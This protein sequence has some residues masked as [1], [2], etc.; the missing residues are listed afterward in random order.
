MYC[1][2]SNYLIQNKLYVNSKIITSPQTPS[3]CK[4]CTRSLK[5]AKICSFRAIYS[6]RFFRFWFFR[7]SY[8]QHCLYLRDI[9]HKNVES[10]GTVKKVLRTGYGSYSWIPWWTLI[11]KMTKL[12]PASK[13]GR[14][15][16]WVKVEHFHNLAL[17]GRYK[18][19]FFA[20]NDFRKF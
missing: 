16:E 15:Y 11:T 10:L 20:I 13:S 5:F 7:K 17:F 19:N 12:D 6:F 14:G 2:K 18:E 3:P 8:L 4:K 9:P 1:Q